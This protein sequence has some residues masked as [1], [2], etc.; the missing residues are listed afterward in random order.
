MNHRAFLSVRNMRQCEWLMNADLA[1]P[2]FCGKATKRGSNYCR[3]HDKEMKK[4]L[5]SEPTNITTPE[6][7]PTPYWLGQFRDGLD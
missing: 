1:R 3:A 7:Q 6:D 2:K 5:E 4:I